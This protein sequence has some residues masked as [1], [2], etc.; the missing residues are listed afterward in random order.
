MI[1]TAAWLAAGCIDFGEEEISPANNGIET[2]EDPI[3]ETT[4]EATITPAATP[5]GTAY[6]FGDADTSDDNIANT[7]FDR[8]ISIVFGGSQATVSGD[9]NGIVSVDGNHVTVKNTTKENIVY[10]LSGTATD[11][12]FKLYSSKKQAIRL[13]G[14]GLTNPAELKN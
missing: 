8:V 2:I 1:L 9:E 7:S 4:F 12:F 13:S 11:G 6:D 10:D 14:L 5:A 3:D